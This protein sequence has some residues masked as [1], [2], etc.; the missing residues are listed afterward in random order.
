MDRQSIEELMI[1]QLGSL[2]SCLN[3]STKGKRWEII[4]RAIDYYNK[5]GWPTTP[6]MDHITGESSSQSQ[7]Q[8]SAPIATRSRAMDTLTIAG[9]GAA[10]EPIERPDRNAQDNTLVVTGEAAEGH[11]ERPRVNA[12]LNIQE[13]VQAVVQI[14]E[15]RQRTSSGNSANTSPPGQRGES[16]ANS[17]RSTTSNS[18]QQ[19]KFATKL[20]P[21][22]SGKE[23][24]NVVRWLERIS[25]VARMYRLTDDVLVLAAV[26][27]LKDRALQWH[28]RQ[29]LETVGTWN[30][31]KFQIRRHFEIKESYTTTLSRIGQRI[32]KSHK[33]KFADYAEAKLDLMQTLSLTER[34]K[35][36]LL[37]DGIKEPVIRKLALSSG[38]R[39]IPDFLEII[40]KVTEDT[41]P[42]KKNDFRSEGRSRFQ[43]KGNNTRPDSNDKAC[44]NCKQTGH[45]S[46]DCP[47][48]KLTCFKCGKEGHL[49]NT[50]PKKSARAG[51]AT[52]N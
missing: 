9:S 40:R 1:N 22:F 18:W 42:N 16:P 52:N 13:I 29:S 38:A 14:M 8:S 46:K 7:E 12:A 15:E 19:I 11:V 45:I 30:E 20:I 2:A 4:D 17:D 39:N 28:N 49:S 36:E 47:N 48:K 27:Q 21:P 5:Y 34:E 10:R 25:S 3:I 24:E 44:F 32:W 35:I 43:S 33:E 23:E 50:C 41:I 51:A 6:I 26:S 37:T 31:F